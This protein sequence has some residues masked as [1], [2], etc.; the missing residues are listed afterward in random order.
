LT[1][2]RIRQ[3]TV[4]DCDAVAALVQ[5]L[6]RLAGMESGTTGATLA[7]AA[8]GPR[9]TMAI[10]LAEDEWSPVGC[11]I[12]QD[13]FS[14]WRGANGVFVVD[15]YV[16]PG[17]RGRGIGLALMREAARLGRARGARFMRLDVE[18]DNYDALRLYRRLGFRRLDRLFQVLDEPAMSRLADGG[19]P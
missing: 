19:V 13:T 8:F 9:P 7:E 12:H 10:L 18:T 14:T 1:A 11:L 3:A 16:K 15:F 2:V 6:A 4:A 5:D 17:H